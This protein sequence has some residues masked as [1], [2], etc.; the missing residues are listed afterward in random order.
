MVFLLVKNREPVDQCKLLKNQIESALFSQ[1][2]KFSQ[3]IDFVERTNN[4]LQYSIITYKV[5]SHIIF[6]TCE[7]FFCYDLKKY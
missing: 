4:Y 7:H 6:N 3:K 5:Y 1:I 2:S